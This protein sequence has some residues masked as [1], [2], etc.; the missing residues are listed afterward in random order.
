MRQVVPPAPSPEP[1]GLD[2]T[3]AHDGTV[4]L[5]EPIETTRLL[6][7]R[8]N[9][10]HREEFAKLAANPRVMR[11]IGDGAVWD[12]VRSDEVF[13]LQ[14]EHWSDHGFGWRSAIHR[15]TGSWIGFI[16]LNYTGPEATEIPAPEVE[17]GW[18]LDPDVWRKGLALEGAF[19]LRDEAFGRI[20]LDRII[21]RFQPDNLASARIM[22][23]IGMRFEREA[24]GR[25]GEIV[26][27]F[28]LHREEWLGQHQATPW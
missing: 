10:H 6:L 20:G 8:W 7:E 16:A 13:T 9:E 24:V 15:T 4:S 18:W 3:V 11:Y 1:R 27:I 14:L 21:G 26:R 19:A 17:I 22:V 12:R 23:R 5:M 2:T 25:H 28:A